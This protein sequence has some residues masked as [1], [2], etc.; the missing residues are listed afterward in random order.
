MSPGLK[1]K[2]AFSLTLKN[3]SGGYDLID[4]SG[5]NEKEKMK[6]MQEKHW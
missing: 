2:A 5:L 4:K 1:E 6:V 3:E